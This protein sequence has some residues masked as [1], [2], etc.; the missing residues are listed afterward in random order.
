M[1]RSPKP[2]V[3]GAIWLAG[4]K[5]AF[6]WLLPEAPYSLHWDG[7]P[8]QTLAKA[9]SCIDSPKLGAK[10]DRKFQRLYYMRLLQHPSLLRRFAAMRYPVRSN[11]S[12][13]LAEQIEVLR[14]RIARGVALDPQDDG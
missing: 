4:C 10:R 11:R 9:W 14:F 12:P 3:V 1:A 7:R 6:G 13:W 5:D 2:F 8:W